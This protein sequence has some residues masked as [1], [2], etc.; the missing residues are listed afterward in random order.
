MK[1]SNNKHSNRVFHNNSSRTNLILHHRICWT[2]T[3]IIVTVEVRMVIIIPTSVPYYKT[4]WWIKR[5]KLISY[6]IIRTVLLVQWK[7]E[8][9]VQQTVPITIQT[10][11]QVPIKIM[12]EHKHLFNNLIHQS[13]MLIIFLTKGKVQRSAIIFWMD[14]L[15]INSHRTTSRWTTTTVELEK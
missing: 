9:V 3:I 10:S 14:H 13:T 2:K 4:F 8:E 11:F 5:P 15:W 6:R 7:M 12:Q 1:V